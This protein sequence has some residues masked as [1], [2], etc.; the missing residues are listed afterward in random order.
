MNRLARLESV[1]PDFGLMLVLHLNF[2][3]AAIA[4][5][6]NSLR[7]GLGIDFSLICLNLFIVL[8]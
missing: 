4:L 2:K 6:F 8:S 7:I 3:E 1:L 5:R